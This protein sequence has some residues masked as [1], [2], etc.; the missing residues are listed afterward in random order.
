MSKGGLLQLKWLLFKHHTRSRAETPP[1]KT[2]V[3]AAPMQQR[4]VD[5]LGSLRGNAVWLGLAISGKLWIGDKSGSSSHQWVQLSLI[6]TVFGLSPRQGISIASFLRI[7]EEIPVKPNPIFRAKIL[8]MCEIKAS[9]KDKLCEMMSLQTG[10]WS[11][12]RKGIPWGLCWLSY[13]QR[14]KLEMGLGRLCCPLVHTL[15]VLTSIHSHYIFIYF[16]FYFILGFS[17]STMLC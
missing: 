4:S 5:S 2:W 1:Y 7:T 14:G 16:S 10:L 17:W 8:C 9:D 11:C 12:V 13:N 6:C 15:G 3:G